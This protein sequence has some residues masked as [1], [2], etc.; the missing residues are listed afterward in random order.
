MPENFDTPVPNQPFDDESSIDFTEL[1]AVIWRAKKKIFL[2]VVAATVLAIIISLILP[3]A[4]KSTATILPETNAS[5]LSALGGPFDIAS[6]AGV[7][8]GEA[9][10]TKLYPDIAKSEA[11]LKNIIYTQYKTDEM[12]SPENLIQLWEISGKTP[13]EQYVTAL[14]IL[15]S[16]L[17]IDVDRMT[18][19][20][21]VSIETKDPELSAD[22]VNNVVAGLNNFMLTK[23]KSSASEQRAWIAERLSEVKVSLDSSEDALTKFREQNRQVA[24][25]PQLQMQQERLM[26][27]VQLNSTLYIELRKQY[28]L[29]KIDE[30][31]N[32]PIINVLDAARPAAFKDK[33]KRAVIVLVV[34]FLAF[35][36]SVGYVL[37]ANWYGGEFKKLMG[38]VKGEKL[39]AVSDQ[40]AGGSDFQRSRNKDQ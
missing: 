39:L 10:L 38:V 37:V 21:T 17:S 1:F 5:K 8:V 4:Y 26:Q 14:K 2:F 13:Y 23:R 6:L 16:A 36:G 24:S 29:A 19:V 28:E 20:M 35:F 11:V 12:S 31:K 7:N 33:P 27:A 32:I 25:S 3:K 18:S 34:F 9:P 30:I 40:P 22:I 15:G